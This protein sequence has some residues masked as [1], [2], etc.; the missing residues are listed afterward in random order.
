M[1]MER[2]EIR[3]APARILIVDD[4]PGIS[5]V[6][7]IKLEREGYV[8]AAAKSAER[9]G[10]LLDQDEFDLILLD[11]R[12]PDG[13]GFELL[14]RLRQHRSLLDT[15]IIVISGLDQPSD[16]AAAL[17]DGAN[18]YIT[19]P[20]DFPIVIARIST[21]LTLKR[22]KEANDR[23]VRVAS[24]DLKKS[25]TV[26]LDRAQQLSENL[27]IGAEMTGEGHASLQMLMEAAETMQGV[28]GDVLELRALRDRR[29]RLTR[30]ATDIGAVVRQAVA[31]N[32]AYAASKRG[33]LRMEFDRELPN[34]RADDA[35]VLQVLENLIDNA[36]KFSPIG[37]TTMVRTRRDG[38]WIVCEVCDHGAGIA[39]KEES[40]L[41]KEYAT[42]SNQ[43][44]GGEKTRGLGLAISREIV[45]LHGGEIGAYNNASG[46][47]ATFWIRLPI[48]E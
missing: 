7:A 46:G 31:R 5:D 33:E 9:A 26:V 17:Q 47:G 20:F 39:K 28:I 24:D 16:V 41:F 13:S 35:R 36:I 22:L 12:L 6:L 27:P 29:M 3:P 11:I 32:E 42:L 15:P 1:D 45:R 34:I 40:L 25:L 19:K 44:T 4:A 48:D 30:L 38:D 37:S 21:Q 43:P 23:F 8:T 2:E 10:T 18:D 14:S